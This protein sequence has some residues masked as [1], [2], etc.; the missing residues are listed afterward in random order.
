MKT[1]RDP[2]LD[3]HLNKLVMIDFYDGD[4]KTG[5]LEYG[6][7]VAPGLPDSTYYSLYIFGKGYLRFRKSVVKKI[8]EK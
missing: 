8:Q 5:V 4:Q 1:H 2:K 6:K 7:P 3:R